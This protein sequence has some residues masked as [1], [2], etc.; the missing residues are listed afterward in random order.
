MG[1][2]AAEVMEVRVLAQPSSGPDWAG[3]AEVDGALAAE[4]G[5]PVEDGAVVEALAA[6]AASADLVEAVPV[7]EAPAEVGSGR[8]LHS[9]SGSW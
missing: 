3:S 5:V 1:A 2:G 8:I 6:V 7:A 9:A 4:A